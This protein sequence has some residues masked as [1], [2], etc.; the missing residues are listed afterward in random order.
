[1][2]RKRPRH[3]R[4][5]AVFYTGVSSGKYAGDKY[6]ISGYIC[7]HEKHFPPACEMERLIRLQ[8]TEFDDMLVTITSMFEFN[9]QEDYVSFNEQ[10]QS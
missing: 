1:M 8:N 6:T 2:L 7:I 10:R 4:Y 5:F 9:N 3:L